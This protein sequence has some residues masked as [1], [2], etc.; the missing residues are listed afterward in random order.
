MSGFYDSVSFLVVGSNKTA[1]IAKISQLQTVTI[2]V[3]REYPAGVSIIL[4]RQ[5]K[6]IW[7]F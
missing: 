2:W 5:K 7:G 3:I 6:R 1:E 4:E